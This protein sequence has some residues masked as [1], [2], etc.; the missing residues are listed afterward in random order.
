MSVYAQIGES[1]DQFQIASNAGFGE[2]IDWIESISSVPTLAALIEDGITEKPMVAMEELRD[3][4]E[5]ESPKD[6]IA[7]IGASLADALEA[8]GE[9]EPL[10]ITNGI[11]PE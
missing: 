5:K 11:E 4:L 6:D 2:F 1:G 3:A 7:D 9:D 10:L 8:A